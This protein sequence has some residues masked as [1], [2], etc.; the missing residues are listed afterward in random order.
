MKHPLHRPVLGQEELKAVAEVLESGHLVQG[1]RVAAFEERL[2][3]ILGIRHVVAVSSGTAALHVCAVALGLTPH[4]EVIVPAFGFPATANAV[5]VTGA[6]AVPADVD[7]ERFAL[8]VESIEAVASERTVGVILVHPF[9]IPAPTADLQALCESRGWWLVEDAAC[10]LG[11]QQGDRWGSGE[12]PVCLSFHPRKTVT[13]GEG[14][15]VATE[16]GDLARRLRT[17]RNHGMEPGVTGWNRFTRAGF[18]YRMSDLGA[19]IGLVQLGRLESIVSERRRVAALYQEAMA[20][21]A[22]VRWPRGY[23]LPDLSCQSVVVE[24][25]SDVDRDDVIARLAERG[26][27]TTLGGYALGDQP[28]FIERY[29]IRSED[30]PCSGRLAKSTLTLPVTVEMNGE[31]VEFVAQSLRAVMGI[32]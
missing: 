17:L 12:L 18:N 5:E 26:V 31:D 3:E 32:L 23:E 2:A 4:D 27:Q 21:V 14:G 28:Y 9:G 7:L 8:T 10:A 15:V 20:S 16:D 13:T 25:D 22:G 30:L 6:R 24:L 29:G 19:A 1:P 11:T